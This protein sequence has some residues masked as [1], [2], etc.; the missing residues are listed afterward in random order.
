MAGDEALDSDRKH[1]RSSSSDEVAEKSSKRHKHR[2]HHRHRH[3]HSSRKRE[4]ESKLVGKDIEAPQLS[5]P[6]PTAASNSRPD[7]DVEEG[8]ILD[9]EGGGGDEVV[10]KK[11][12]SSGA[13]SGEIVS[14]GVGDQFD[15]RNL[16]CSN[17][18]WCAYF[19]FR[20]LICFLFGR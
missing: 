6:C 15:K 12:T 9:E 16:V 2:H 7:D 3:R 17:C 11:K 4:E 19:L 13:E 5:V 10:A 1:R 18:P 20:L 8:E 14:I